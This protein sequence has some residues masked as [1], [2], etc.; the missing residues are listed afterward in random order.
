[1][2]TTTPANN[3]TL[4]FMLTPTRAPNILF[5]ATLSSVITPPAGRLHLEVEQGGEVLV[6]PA[7]GLLFGAD[8]EF[9]S[10]V[11]AQ[12]VQA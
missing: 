3:K 4:V 12:L 9:D 6:V 8:A 11:A 1:M 10:L 7:G 2:A 5:G